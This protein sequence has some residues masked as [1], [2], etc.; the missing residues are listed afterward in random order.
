MECKHM[1]KFHVF[2]RVLFDLWILLSGEVCSQV[3]RTG[4][5]RKRSVFCAHCCAQNNNDRRRRLQRTQI[6]VAEQQGLLSSFCCKEDVR[7][8]K[9]FP[10]F[11][12]KF[13]RIQI[14]RGSG[15]FSFGQDF[16]RW[17]LSP[18]ERGRRERRAC[19]TG[20]IEKADRRRL[21]LG[22]IRFCPVP[23]RF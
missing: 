2:Q 21:C 8:K 19:V 18:L 5:Q 1:L 6:F 13:Q 14:H 7:K 22:Q 20:I 17:S 23:G 16:D 9:G 3:L 4:E 15:V 12:P 10:Y 11:S